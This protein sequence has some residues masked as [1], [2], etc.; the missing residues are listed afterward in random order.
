M[1]SFE[2]ASHDH[3]EVQCR[4]DTVLLAPGLLLRDN[5]CRISNRPG[6]VRV[7]T[8]QYR[9]ASLVLVSGKVGQREGSSIPPRQLGGYGGIS[10]RQC[11]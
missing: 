7:S 9:V 3:S 6:R 11:L 1:V 4:A 5:G 2:C 8:L 10:G